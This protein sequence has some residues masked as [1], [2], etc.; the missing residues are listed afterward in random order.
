MLQHKKRDMIIVSVAVRKSD[1]S[2]PEWILRHVQHG[3]PKILKFPIILTYQI[4][5]QWKAK[6]MLIQKNGKT[7]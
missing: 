4:S 6:E 5:Q 3:T 7:V 1:N 2:G